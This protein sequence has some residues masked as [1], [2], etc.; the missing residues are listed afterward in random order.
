MLA[1][2]TALTDFLR[3]EGGHI[4]YCIRP[5]ERCKGY[6]TD[7]LKGALAFCGLIGLHD[8]IISCDKENKASAGVIKNC[9]GVLDDEFYSETFHVVVQRY[10]IS[11]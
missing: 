10:K 2:R 8:I 6:G 9:G 5:T 11:T 7:M 4:G 1:I 3:N